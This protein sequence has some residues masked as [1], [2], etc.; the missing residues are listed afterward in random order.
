MSAAAKFRGS[1]FAAVLAGVAL[2]L[3][4]LS[5]VG[6]E[7]QQTTPEPGFRPPGH[8][9]QAFLDH[10]GD[11]SIDV[12]PTMIRRIDRTAHSFASQRQIV[13]FLNEN[14]IATATARRDR[15][16]LGALERSSQWVIFQQGLTAVAETVA[17]RAA[18]A[19]YTLVMEILVP[20]DEAVFGIEVYIVDAQGRNAFSFLLN[21]HHRM[22][23]EARLTASGS[24]EA[25]RQQMITN[26]TRLGLLA[27]QAQIQGA[28]ECM[29]HEEV[30]VTRGSASVLHDFDAPLATGTDECERRSDTRPSADRTRASALQRR[31]PIHRGLVRR[32]ATRSCGLTSTSPA[33]AV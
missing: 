3:A 22:F 26:A 20:G 14:R 25:A 16:D 5:A 32:T 24:S 19:D 1:R 33:G 29:Q 9:V 23:A 7:A 10:V 6:H 2:A 31:T 18:G 17:N 12:L 4:C 27:L 11:M 28:R 8:E 21:S 30:P 13:D 15:I